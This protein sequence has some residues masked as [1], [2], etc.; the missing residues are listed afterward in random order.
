MYIYVSYK[1]RALLFCFLGKVCSATGIFPQDNV[2]IWKMSICLEQL[3]S[4]PVEDLPAQPLL[5]A[6]CTLTDVI[7]WMCKFIWVFG[8]EHVIKVVCSNECAF[9]FV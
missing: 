5:Q 2:L 9:Y 3:I 1:H 6:D 4:P 8:R 7:S